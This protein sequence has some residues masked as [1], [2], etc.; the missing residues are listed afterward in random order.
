[1]RYAISGGTFAK[2]KEI[3]QASGV[4]DDVEDTYKIFKYD[5][6]EVSFDLWVETEAQKDT[7]FSDLKT[8][9]DQH[10]GSV[11]WH[12]CSHWEGAV[13]PCI[14]AESYGGD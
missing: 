10:G 1:M 12:E 3:D 4:M 7:L 13:T 6:G 11:S 14:I 8:F 2:D 5:N 9:V